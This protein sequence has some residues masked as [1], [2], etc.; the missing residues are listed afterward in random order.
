MSGYER[1]HHG[2]GQG[3][4]WRLRSRRTAPSCHRPVGRGPAAVATA[5]EAARP[6]WTCPGPARAHLHRCVLA[7]K[8]CVG[9]VGA[10]SAVAERGGW[11][12]RHLRVLAAPDLQVVVL[13]SC[14]GG[15]GTRD[16]RRSARGGSGC[17]PVSRVA[18][19]SRDSRVRPRRGLDAEGDRRRAGVPAAER[20][21]LAES[22]GIRALRVRCARPAPLTGLGENVHQLRHMHPRTATQRGVAMIGRLH[23]A[24]ASARAGRLPTGVRL[25]LV[26]SV[27]TCPSHCWN[28]RL[29]LVQGETQAPRRHRDHCP[30]ESADTAADRRV[31]L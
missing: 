17:R 8:W 5:A 16:G 10:G 30:A 15:R 28:S 4:F 2:G 25:G 1:G 24:T 6:G 22:E 26:W 9:L 14:V 19:G 13:V 18:R 27:R 3:Q 29:Q 21:H 20:D 12:R 7:F 23:M 31:P 11:P